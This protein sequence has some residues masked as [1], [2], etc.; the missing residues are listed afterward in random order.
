MKV[1]VV[2]EILPGGEVVIKGVTDLA[3]KAISAA[4]CKKTALEVGAK[5]GTVDAKTIKPVQV[6]VTEKATLKASVG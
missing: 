3:G 5:F 1:H 2:M 4:T 6:A